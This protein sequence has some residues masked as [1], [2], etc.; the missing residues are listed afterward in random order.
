[1]KILIVHNRYRESGGEDRVV[2]LE[3]A[4]LARHGHTVATYIEDNAQLQSIPS[5]VV[6]ARTIWSHA[7]YRHVGDA[8]ARDR[9]DLVHVHNTLPLV[10]PAVYYAARRAGIPVVQTLHNYRLVCP[11]AV[12]FRDTG[13]C[14]ECLG[15]RTALPAVQHACYRGSRAA[16]AAVATMLFV[17]KAAGTWQR[18]IETFIA[19]SQF[20]RDTFVKGGLD[21]NRIVVKPHFVDPDPGAGSGSGGYAI[22]VGRLSAEKGIEVLLDAWSRLRRRIPLVVVGDGPFAS[23]VAAAAARMEGVRWFGRQQPSQVQ[24]LIA[25]AAFL[26][27]PSVAYETFGQVI[28]EAYASGT[29]VVAAAGGAGAEMVSDRETGLLVRPGDRD[30]LASR[31]DWL[32]EHPE[33]LARMRR[34]ARLVYETR[35]TAEANY[36]Q[37]ATIYS[38]ALTGTHQAALSA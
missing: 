10:S 18:T 22:F 34:A 16:T 36:R 31:I 12:C 7:A 1:M 30:D 32:L 37:L 21:A 25:D 23:Q 28:G 33:R 19:P 9:I 11:N 24:H 3:S 15:R 38:N 5:A 17:H 14:V 8:I 27:F 13:P 6:A 29:P 20:A 35:L 2:A 4:L 26:V